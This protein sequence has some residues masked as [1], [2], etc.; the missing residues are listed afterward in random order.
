MST[1][2]F[3]ATLVRIGEGA[4]LNIPFDPDEAWG[5]KERHFVTGSIAGRPFR[6]VIEMNGPTQLSI[7]PAWLRDNEMSEDSP[8]EVILSPDGHQ[9]ESLAED[10]AA[11]LVA[12]LEAQTFFE[13]VAPFYRNNYIRWIE[14]AKR[15][16]TRAKRIAETV[17]LLK[18]GQK[19]R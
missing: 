15:P 4:A 18:A 16:E 1:K 8:I 19:Q 17:N 12:E 6:G 13:S 14:Q 2:S 5:T 10:I 7:G 11:A 9:V 3:M